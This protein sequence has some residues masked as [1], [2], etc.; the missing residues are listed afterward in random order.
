MGPGEA[1]A[2]ALAILIG[3]PE[4]IGLDYVV[5]GAWGIER[6]EDFCWGGA[7]LAPALPRWHATM[8]LKHQSNSLYTCSRPGD[9]HGFGPYG[10]IQ[11]EGRV[12]AFCLLNL[13]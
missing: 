8:P 1:C 5:G 11:S 3:V 9:E 2:E 4:G 6:L 12:S 10:H 7:V 13:P